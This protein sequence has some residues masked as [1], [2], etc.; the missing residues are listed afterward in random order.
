MEERKT[1]TL[2]QMIAS[3]CEERAISAWLVGG[4]VRD[5]LLGRTPTD[6]DIAVAA[7]GLSLARA[8]A[9]QTGGAF[10]A[11]DSERGAGRVVY[12]T[13]VVDLVQL[14]APTIEADLSLRDVTIN[15]LAIPLG[16]VAATPELSTCLSALIDPCGGRHDLDMRKLRACAPSS[17]LD[18]PLRILRVARFAAVL[19]MEITPEMD[20]A[21]RRHAPLIVAVAG[22]RVREE[23]LKLLSCPAAVRWLCYLDE[24]RV[25]T[26]LF[27][28]L[29]PARTCDQPIVHFLPVLGHLLE[30]VV[31]IE[32]LLDDV[33]CG[34]VPAAVQAHPDLERCPPYIARLRQ[35]CAERGSSGYPRAAL[36]KLAA[37]L[38]DNAKPQTKQPKPDGGVSFHDH[39]KMG[40]RVTQGVSQRL[41]L[42]RH[43]SAYIAMIVREHMRPGQLMQLDVLT[44]RAIVRFFHDT[45]E[46]GP[47]ILLHGLADHMAARGPQID[48]AYWRSHLAWTGKMLDAYWHTPEKPPPPLVNGAVLIAELG[49]QPGRLIGALLSEIKEAHAAGEIQTREEALALA[50]RYVT[51]QARVTHR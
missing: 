3:F 9:D 6:I 48:P 40:A 31:C 11:L 42:S 7:D 17:L 36:L 26:R 39:Q 45:G 8:C 10:V 21:I 35:H 14:R 32:W 22:E 29:E 12:G 51:M 19:H 1:A 27:P 20:S 24:V 33:P 34:A 30:T 37:L 46:A 47:D 38:H 15:A 28:E 4:T 18:D 41:R 23:L 44:Q 49:L 43:E 5:L 25:L 50:R 13:Q 2:M 16:V